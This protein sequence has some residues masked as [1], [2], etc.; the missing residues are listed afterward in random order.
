M[1]QDLERAQISIPPL[2]LK[3]REYEQDCLTKEAELEELRAW[4][5][6]VLDTMR[7]APPE[8]APARHN[9]K[10]PHQHVSGSQQ[11]LSL[12]IEAPSFSVDALPQTT[13]ASNDTT[14]DDFAGAS[15]HSSSQLSQHGSTPK[16]PKPRPLSRDLSA[17]TSYNNSTKTSKRSK[18]QRPALRPISPNRRHSVVGGGIPEQKDMVD[19][20]QSL[21]LRKR[22]GSSQG[23]EAT[24]FELA[25]AAS[26]PF[27]PGNFTTGTGRWLEED[28]SIAEL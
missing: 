25:L 26:T 9:P 1:R 7:L 17:R 14:F 4:Q 23:G 2:R 8:P 18:I 28:E 6:R 20:R 10:A 3:I 15:M 21:P 13:G 22:R 5:S 11:S 27:T 24:D 16:R 12:Q 19:S